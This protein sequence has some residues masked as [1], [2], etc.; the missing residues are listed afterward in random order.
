[1]LNFS[2]ALIELYERAEQV[3]PRA[4][5]YHLLEVMNGL[6]RFDGALLG[7][8]HAPAAPCSSACGAARSRA[9]EE[10]SA[11][12]CDSCAER[13]ASLES[14]ALPQPM[15]LHVPAAGTNT[16]WIT[17]C[18]ADAEEDFDTQERTS[19]QAAWP[20][21]LR[22]IALNR[23]R[24][25]ARQLARKELGAG[26]LIDNA[27][28]IESA[29]ARFREMLALEWPDHAGTHLPT[30]AFDA[31]CDGDA[32]IGKKIEIHFIEVE[33]CIVCHAHA[34]PVPR[35]LTRTESVVA[36]Y[37]ASGLNN[38]EVAL[39]LGVSENTVR[40]HL[41]Q[42]YSKLGVHDKAQLANTLMH[43]SDA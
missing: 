10:W 43:L 8:G 4:F 28:N 14:T 38:R 31:Y 30:A 11:Q 18:R 42:A 35:G 13:R 20:H 1:M 19:L 2:R 24:F 27:G 37:F 40:T 3:T 6:V 15:V 39:A 12:A 9:I 32:Y 33:G 29:E 25:L 21:L 41:K 36:R 22:S 17:L 34:R 26:A 5:P 16:P 7:T 23:E